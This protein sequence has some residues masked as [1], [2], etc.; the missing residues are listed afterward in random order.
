MTVSWL[1]PL[2]YLAFGILTLSVVLACVRLVRGPAFPD[3]VMALDLV[4]YQ[5]V[6]LTAIY[7]VTTGH[8]Q[9]LDVALAAGL[10]AF[11]GTIAFAR[12]IHAEKEEQDEERVR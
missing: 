3:R 4:I 7:A 9:F 11:V 5:V 2:L 6:A 8:P 1:W 12:Y 10:I